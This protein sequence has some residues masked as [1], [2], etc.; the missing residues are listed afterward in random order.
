[1]NEINDSVSSQRKRE[2]KI[3]EDKFYEIDTH[4]V[5]V[6]LNRLQEAREEPLN[7][8]SNP[9]ALIKKRGQPKETRLNLNMLQ[10]TNVPTTEKQ[11]TILELV[12]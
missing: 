3:L 1:M 6:F 5:P 10:E 8:L 9:A 2:L 7:P 4:Q 12:K 11:A